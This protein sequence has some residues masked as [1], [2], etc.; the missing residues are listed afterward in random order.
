MI[1][2][3]TEEIKEAMKSKDTEK[4]DVLRA[5]KSAAT[6][7]MKESHAEAITDDMVLTAVN[8][9][10]KQLKQTMASLAGKEDTDLYKSTEYRIKVLS[11]YL[12]K[13]LSE[14]EV[15]EEIKKIL[16]ALPADA[17]FGDKMREVMKVLKG[18]ADGSLIQ[19][20]LK[21]L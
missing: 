10:I 14:D 18:K 13:Q 19:K 7:S 9:E 16:A 11:E 17:K 1:N 6:L 15:K 8:K 4:R 2:K 12:P 3:I 20:I 21:E 5:I